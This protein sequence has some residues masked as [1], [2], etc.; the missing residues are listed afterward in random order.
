MDSPTK[1]MDYFMTTI[2]AIA[3][4][5]APGIMALSHYKTVIG[6]WSY[7][8]FECIDKRWFKSAVLCNSAQSTEI[9]R[10]FFFFSCMRPGTG[11]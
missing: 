3:S 2:E 6:L 5:F 4:G 8:L 1:S 11:P 9:L 7:K 10:Q